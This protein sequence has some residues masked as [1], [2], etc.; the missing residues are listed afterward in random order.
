MNTVA[1]APVGKHHANQLRS[2]VQPEVSAET[3]DLKEM[4]RDAD[5]ANCRQTEAMRCTAE[6][7]DHRVLRVGR[8]DGVDLCLGRTI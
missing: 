8:D 6:R 7:N 5:V 4:I 1:L 2:N 3:M